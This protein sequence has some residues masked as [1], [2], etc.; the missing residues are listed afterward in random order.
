FLVI[1]RPP[2]STLFP[3]T[4]LFRSHVHTHTHTHKQTAYS[5]SLGSA[6]PN[7]PIALFYTHTHTHR[8]S[9]QCGA[10]YIVLSTGSE[11]RPQP[12]VAGKQHPEHRAPTSPTLHRAPVCVCVHV[13]VS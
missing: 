9:V 6:A 1:P 4:T 12:C 10:A 13:N 3:H 11:V 2:R 8:R 7:L 5:S